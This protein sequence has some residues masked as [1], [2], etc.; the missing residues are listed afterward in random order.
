M[1]SPPGNGFNLS[2]I[3]QT[4]SEKCQIW[5]QVWRSSKLVKNTFYAHFEDFWSPSYVISKLTPICVN[6]IMSVNF[7]WTSS[8]VQAFDFL[9][10]DIF[11][12]TWHLLTYC[13]PITYVPITHGQCDFVW[14]GEIYHDHI[15]I[16]GCLTFSSF[17]K[18]IL[19]RFWCMTTHSEA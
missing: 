16:W 7:L 3:D 5:C 19:G 13:C 12:T 9:A 2:G 14:F 4:L 17:L 10:F 18:L 1:Q 11:L 15:K 8:I 6:L